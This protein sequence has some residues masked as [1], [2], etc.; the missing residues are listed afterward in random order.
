MPISARLPIVGIV[1][2]AGRARR[3]PGCA[4][5]KE[6][7]PIAVDPRGTRAKV[8]SEFVV[9]GLIDAGVDRI[10]FVIAPD[11]HD[12]RT[13]YGDGERFGVPFGYLYQHTP[14]GMPDAIDLAYRQLR[15]ATVLMGMPDTV[16]RP[17]DGLKRLK[18]HYQRMPADVAIAVAPATEPERLG[19]VLFDRA[20]W[21]TSI[22]DKPVVA[23]SNLV[24]TLACWGPV[25]TEF[26]HQYLT[27][28]PRHGEIPLG[29]IF[30]AA[31]DCGLRVSV[32]PFV[33]GEYVD[34]GTV[35][36]LQSARRLAGQLA[37]PASQ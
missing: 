1:P 18:E 7:L 28:A 29:L 9:E 13:H 37:S 12:I 17:V 21:A 31:I 14:T 26:L 16:M 36:G 32:L 23:P 8:I 30:Q 35:K 25:F 11:K 34:A 10:H 15:N 3:L 4:C 33:H 19:P 27:A 5:S 22:V 24:W 20:G 2:A 6:M